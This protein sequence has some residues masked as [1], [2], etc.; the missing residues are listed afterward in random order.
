MTQPRPKRRGLHAL[1]MFLS[2][3]ATAQAHQQAHVHGRIQLGVAL[4]GSELVIDIHAPLESLLGF[5][6]QPR[7]A[8][9]KALAADWS[10]RLRDGGTLLR[11]DPEA[12]CVLTHAE[13]SAPVLGWGS[14]P[15]HATA[16]DGHA[17]LEGQWVFRCAQPSA[18]R[19][20]NV[21]FFEAS[22][23]ARVIEV[24]WAVGGKQGRQVLKRP[25]D[26]VNLGPR[27]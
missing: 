20:L 8:T 23:H 18:L 27:R 6:R 3:M 25:Q 4:E 13:L 9:E 26:V 15:G 16:Q 5:E 14:S 24:Q 1:V 2:C 21:G 17:D 19:R 12:R 7:T 22:A 10:A 11:L